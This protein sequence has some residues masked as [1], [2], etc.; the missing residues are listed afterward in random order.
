MCIFL[1]QMTKTEVN[2]RALFPSATATPSQV[3]DTLIKS[4]H[5]VSN[6]LN[7]AER[8]TPRS[9]LTREAKRNSR[10]RRVRT[11][12]R[13]VDVGC[14]M[15]STDVSPKLQNKPSGISSIPA[16]VRAF[17]SFTIRFC[18][19]ASQFWNCCQSVSC[20][21]PLIDYKANN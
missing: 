4:R 12:G 1:Y 11:C 15:F 21:S 7:G 8:C 17:S 5:Y 13:E 16:A 20:G 3:I 14:R 18:K 9:F 10:P 19:F 6:S 2:I